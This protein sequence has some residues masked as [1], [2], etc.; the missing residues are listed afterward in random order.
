MAQRAELR[1]ASFEARVIAFAT[2]SL[3]LVVVGQIAFFALDLDVFV[4]WLLNF[5]SFQVYF[6]GFWCLADGQTPGMR[7]VRIRVAALDGPRVTLGRAGVRALVFYV[8]SPI[9]VLTALLRKD[10]RGLHDLAAR[11]QVVVG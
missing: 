4:L 1:P 6:A 10:Q 8:T 7:M 11:T 5:L 2:D 3:P 9:A